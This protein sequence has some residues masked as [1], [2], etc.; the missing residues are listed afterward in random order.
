[1][2]FLDQWAQGAFL[3]VWGVALTLA[4]ISLQ[5]LG[6]TAHVRFA[7]L[8]YVTGPRRIWPPVNR[9]KDT[10]TSLAGLA[11]AIGV[12][13][14]SN[15][16][17]A[18]LLGIPHFPPTEYRDA[19]YGLVRAHVALILELFFLRKLADHP[20]FKS[21]WVVAWYAFSVGLALWG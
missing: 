8:G 3:A 18:E 5:R 15:P 21:N 7:A 12:L 17:A 19:V 13:A 16:A 20:N 14:A 9:Q 1:M 4:Y 2:H 11:L 10:V 6:N